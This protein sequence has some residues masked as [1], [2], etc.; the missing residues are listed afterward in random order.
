MNNR[1]KED[2]TGYLTCRYCTISIHYATFYELR[3]HCRASH[4]TCLY[5]D[6]DKVFMNDDE[7]RA[8]KRTI[9]GDVWCP[10]CDVFLGAPALAKAHMQGNHYP[11]NACNR[12]HASVK[13]KMY[14]WDTYCHFCKQ[15]F[16]TSDLKQ[17]HMAKTR[18]QLCE[19]CWFNTSQSPAF[20]EKHFET[21]KPRSDPNNSWWEQQTYGAF[22][23]DAFQNEKDKF[24][25]QTEEEPGKGYDDRESFNGQK[26]NSKQQK[27]SSRK[28]KWNPKP[29]P[30]PP[31]QDGPLDIYAILKVHP[32]SS[33]GD[34]KRAARERRIETHPD[35][36]K[37]KNMSRQEE[38]RIDEEAKLVGWAADIVLDAEKRAQ[39][40]WEVQG[41]KAKHGR[42][43]F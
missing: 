25:A 36:M 16:R 39:H 15:Y 41:W 11:C 21:H 8:H 7:L 3:A 43:G 12:F 9:H 18:H 24:K 5:C 42:H 32:Q 28:P 26:E 10:I 31:R 27:D 29:P 38:A 30:S 40:D 37:R 1:P 20:W 34:I 6:V 2:R 22:G 35:R 33:A 14:H 17:E 23:G 4:I 13:D 19:I